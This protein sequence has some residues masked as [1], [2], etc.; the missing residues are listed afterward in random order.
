[1]KVLVIEDEG[2]AAERLIRLLEAVAGSAE[3]ISAN[4]LSKMLELPRATLY[5]NIATP[6]AAVMCRCQTA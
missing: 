1:M 3:P 2:I 4:E 5:R 6:C